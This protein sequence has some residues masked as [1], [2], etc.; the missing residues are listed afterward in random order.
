MIK[1]ALADVNLVPARQYKMQKQD[2]QRIKDI[3]ETEVFK[4]FDG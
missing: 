3:L 2:M 1:K 4:Y